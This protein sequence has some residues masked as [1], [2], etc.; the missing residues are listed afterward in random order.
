MPTEWGLAL[1]RHITYGKV[2]LASK[3]L[4]L[5]GRSR[6]ARSLLTS[7]RA[8]CVQ[9]TIGYARSI[10]S[11]VDNAL[12]LRDSIVAE[13]RGDWPCVWQQG[14]SPD[15]VEYGGMILTGE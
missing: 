8:F 2:W 10:I 9:N 15:W 13:E 3:L 5:S 4:Q 6:Y 11:R 14:S 12:V 1:Q 7:F